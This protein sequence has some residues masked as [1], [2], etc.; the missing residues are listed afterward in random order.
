MD[1]E[2]WW[3]TVHGSCKELNMTERL[4][5]HTHTQTY[6][7][8]ELQNKLK[9]LGRPN[10]FLWGHSGLHGIF[11]STGSLIRKVCHSR[12]LPLLMGAMHN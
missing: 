10:P 1:K 9:A 12:S 7:Y 3:A 4:V 8:T 5:R 2:A 11:Y 6:M